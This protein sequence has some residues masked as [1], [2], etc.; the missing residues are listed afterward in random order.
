MLALVQLRYGSTTDFRQ[1]IMSWADVAKVS[2]VSPCTA[3]DAV[4]RFH[5]NGDRFV[6]KKYP[7]KTAAFPQELKEQLVRPATLIEMRFLPIRERARRHSEEMGV[8]VSAYLL[9]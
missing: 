9:R 2:G 7:S 3:R 8:R 5:K 6:P 1:E 4:S